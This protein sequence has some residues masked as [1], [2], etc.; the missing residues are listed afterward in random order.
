MQKFHKGQ[1]SHTIDETKTL[2][3]RVPD[4]L[5]QRSEIT[6]QDQSPHLR[7]GPFLHL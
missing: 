7:E 3:N 2:D 5:Q 4:H 1:T 6:L